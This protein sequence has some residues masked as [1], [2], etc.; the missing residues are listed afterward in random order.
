MPGHEAPA[1]LNHQ[2]K[3]IFKMIHSNLNLDLKG[4]DIP[5][6]YPIDTD[7][8]YR[9]EM[10]EKGSF[11]IKG[12]SSGKTPALLRGWTNIY[13]IKFVP[14]IIYRTATAQ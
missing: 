14:V 9:T 11:L 8:M 10:A 7:E 3:E 12:N 1:S 5:A 6:Q 4:L 13:L 2:K